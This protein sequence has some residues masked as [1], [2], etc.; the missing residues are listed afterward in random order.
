MTDEETNLYFSQNLPE[1]EVCTVISL[2]ASSYITAR[3]EVRVFVL[4]E[5][6]G[7]VQF[8]PDY[9]PAP[10]LGSTCAAKSWPP[11]LGMDDP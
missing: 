1:D 8:P 9:N 10:W 7:I 4:Q 6:C 2:V 5:S 11:A 3:F